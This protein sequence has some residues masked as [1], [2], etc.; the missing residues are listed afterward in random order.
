GRRR[1]VRVRRD[2]QAATAER[3]VARRRRR[4]YARRRGPRTPPAGLSGRPRAGGGRVMTRR[5]ATLVPAL[6]C[7]AGATVIAFG[8]AAALW[9]L[10]GT[11]DA[12]GLSPIGR[13]PD[14]GLLPAASAGLGAAGA[15]VA[16]WRRGPA[17]AAAVEPWAQVAARAGL[18][19]VL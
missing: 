19:F 15:A 8:A 13:P 16:L 14:E 10:T 7:A 6:R 12:L 3:G 4:R 11:L 5:F 2:G 1:A 18:A 9:F 17:A